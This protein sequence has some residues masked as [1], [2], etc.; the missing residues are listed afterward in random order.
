ICSG[1]GAMP[2]AAF[3]GVLSF[4]E[5]ECRIC[6]FMVLYALGATLLLIEP[7]VTVISNTRIVRNCFQDRRRELFRLFRTLNVGVPLQTGWGCLLAKERNAAPLSY[8]PQFFD[9]SRNGVS[10]N[11]QRGVIT[12]PAVSPAFYASDD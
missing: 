1:V 4:A 11:H 2:G 10:E 5:P 12:G 9:A 3:G 7:P 6:V 8:L